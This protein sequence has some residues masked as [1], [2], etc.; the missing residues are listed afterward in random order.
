[1]RPRIRAKQIEQRF[2]AAIEKAMALAKSDE[3]AYLPGWCG[4]HPD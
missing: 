1:M 4:P 3:A 2:S